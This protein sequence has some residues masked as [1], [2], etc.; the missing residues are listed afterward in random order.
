MSIYLDLEIKK[1]VKL[2]TKSQSL[3]LKQKI[4]KN[5]KESCIYFDELQL[6]DDDMKVVGKYFLQNNKVSN[7]VF[8]LTLKVK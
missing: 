4:H 2:L 7:I 5:K 6:T 1:L 8:T 3:D